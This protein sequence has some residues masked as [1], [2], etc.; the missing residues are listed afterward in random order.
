M[1]KEIPELLDPM[2][3]GITNYYTA[4]Q[5]L[6]MA[7]FKTRKQTAAGAQKALKVKLQK[8]YVHS[9]VEELFNKSKTGDNHVLHIC[10]L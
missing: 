9:T 4:L 5:L 7:H 3:V 2:E 8:S 6:L 10:R 1:M